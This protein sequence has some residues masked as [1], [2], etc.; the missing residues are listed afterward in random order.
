MEVLSTVCASGCVSLH[1]NNIFS[2][3]FVGRQL[4][5]EILTS[6]EGVTVRK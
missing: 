4:A 2:C 6:K 5:A 1:I 3:R